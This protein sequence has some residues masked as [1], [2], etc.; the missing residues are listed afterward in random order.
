MIKMEE[1]RGVIEEVGEEGLEEDSFGRSP[2]MLV[3]QQIEPNF[4]FI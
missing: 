3:E 1:G 4:G 2:R